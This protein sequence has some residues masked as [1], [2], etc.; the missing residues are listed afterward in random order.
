MVS[1]DILDHHAARLEVL[2]R[3]LQWAKPALERHCEAILCRATGFALMA[4]LVL[5]PNRFPASARTIGRAYLFRFWRPATLGELIDIILATLIWPFGIAI[6]VL[7]FTRK[8]GPVIAKRFGRS[9][10]RQ[11]FDQ[12]RVALTSGLPPPWYYVFELYRPG[13]MSRV[14]AYLTRGETKHGTNRLLAKARGSSS[15]L[16]DK[17]AFA[18]FC[19]QRQLRTL[20]VF[21]SIH[22]GEVRSVGCARSALPKTDLF[23]KPVRGRGGKGAERWD[24][25]GRGIYRTPDGRSLSGPQLIERLRN[26]SCSQ[27]Y[28]VQKRARNHAAIR[29]LS[30]GALNTIRIISCLD[31]RNRPEIIGAVL[32]MAVGTSVTVDNVHA[33]AIAAAVNLAE[34]RLG[35]ATYMGIDARAGWIDCHP[36]TRALITGRVLPMWK[37][38]CELVRRAHSVFHD[39]VIVGW[40]VA[41]VAGGPCLVE[42]NN[43]PDLDLIQRPLRTAFGQG[44]LGELLAFHLTQSENVWRRSHNN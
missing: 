30:N 1:A 12:L 37:D 26:M 3:G 38:A 24:Y 33:G 6:C 19:E 43:G 20:P 11:C 7:W 17:E 2:R 32:K 36:I 15:P 14:R 41:I 31:E 39:W 40:D 22:D 44:R 8:N 5:T 25:S 23:V 42:G 27:P 28:L 18:H 16:S 34:G 13:G 21:F 9:R 10:I 29:D 4:N 35:Q